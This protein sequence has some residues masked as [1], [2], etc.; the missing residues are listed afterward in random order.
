MSPAAGRAAGD[1][2]SG[3]Q[4]V[5]EVFFSHSFDAMSQ[6]PLRAAYPPLADRDSY[7]ACAGFKEI[8]TAAA[9]GFKDSGNLLCRK[10][11]NVYGAIGRKPELRIRNISQ[12]FTEHHKV[13]LGKAAAYGV[14]G[15]SIKSRLFLRKDPGAFD[16]SIP[17][18]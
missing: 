4:T 17:G 13:L 7:T 18:F 8:F 3:K 12:H 1:M 2:D 16:F 9:C 5:G 10:V 6:K 15:Y 11:E 14:I